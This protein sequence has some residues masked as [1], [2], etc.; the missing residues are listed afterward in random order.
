[1]Y[2]Y[3]PELL[4]LR[5]HRVTECITDCLQT[6]DNIVIPWGAAHMPGIERA[7][8]EWGGTI[9]ERRRIQIW[10]WSSP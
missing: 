6:Y 3:E 9:A 2:Y 10:G 1:M 7:I 5:N 4:E 8:L